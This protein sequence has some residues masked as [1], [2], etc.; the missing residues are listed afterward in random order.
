MLLAKGERGNRKGSECDIG[1]REWRNDR[2]HEWRG[3]AIGDESV[4]VCDWVQ[5]GVV[6]AVEGD[7]ER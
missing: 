2:K 7:V 4:S 6:S 5:E 3:V 1:G